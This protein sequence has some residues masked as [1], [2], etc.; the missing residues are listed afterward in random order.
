LELAGGFAFGV[1]V[2]E[3]LERVSL[4]RG[5]GGCDGVVELVGGEFVFRQFASSYLQ[6]QISPRA[7]S[8]QQ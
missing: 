6:R 2:G 4:F 1:S 5:A 3:E 8:W 7:Q